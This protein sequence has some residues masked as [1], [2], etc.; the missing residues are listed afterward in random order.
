MLFGVAACGNDNSKADGSGSSTKAGSSGTISGVTVTGDV[1]SEP[2]VD[3][4]AP[5]K[6]SK[7]VS[8]VITAGDGNPVVEGQSVLLQL[9][10]ANGRTGKKA[11]STY[12]SGTPQQYTIA[13]GSFFPDAIKGLVG[14]KQGSR[15]AFASTVKTLFGAS[16][17]TSA[18]QYGLKPD[19]SMVMVA[20]IMSVQPKDVVKGPDGT[21]KNAPSGLPTVVAQGDK[22]T[23]LNYTKAAKKPSNKLQVIPLTEGTGPVAR[24]DSLVTF[25]YFGE[26]YGAKKPFDES[27][28]KEPVT[29]A[30]GTGGLIKAWDE[31]L[32][33]LKRG[34]RVMIV[35]PAKYG[36][37]A[38]GN[39]KG[40]IAKNATLVFIVD[41]L[42]VDN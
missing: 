21:K 26:Q 7:T 33:G 19:D 13:Q 39:P 42:G 2:K 1:G 11:I 38:A 23:N 37:G 27:F 9:Y 5:L 41:I 28:S 40:G 12:D 4:K 10:L 18:A 25:N 15:V 24:D 36:Y 30:L 22:V 20:D 3:I 17:A 29:F 14:Q 8:Q 32:V 6:A 31:G 16:A 35:A 34:S